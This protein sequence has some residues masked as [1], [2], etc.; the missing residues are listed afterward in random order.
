V[1]LDDVP[2]LLIR[3]RRTCR[4]GKKL[5]DVSWSVAG[6]GSFR[7]NAAAV[8]LSTEQVRRVA[9]ATSKR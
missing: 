2:D 1:T 3:R 9:G 5:N 8:E 7:A 4:P 6:R